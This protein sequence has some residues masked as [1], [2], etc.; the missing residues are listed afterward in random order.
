[1]RVILALDKRKK[2]TFSRY[3]IYIDTTRHVM[4]CRDCR[5][6]S[7]TSLWTVV[8]NEGKGYIWKKCLE[9]CCLDCL[10]GNQTAAQL[11]KGQQTLAQYP[12]RQIS[13]SPPLLLPIVF[14]L[15]IAIHSHD[16]CK[17]AW[18]LLLTQVISNEQRSLLRLRPL[19][20]RSYFHLDLVFTLT[21]LSFC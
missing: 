15:G 2:K 12:F 7:R 17:A 11:V 8:K 3:T 14:E 4:K 10:I 16:E 5:Q 6:R 20:E 18:R 13:M 19:M 1:M 9:V 21:W